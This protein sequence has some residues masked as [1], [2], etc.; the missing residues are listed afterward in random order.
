MAR[1][2][3][4]ALLLF[5]LLGALGAAPDGGFDLSDALPDNENKKPTAIPKKPSAGDDFDLGDAVVDGENDDPRPPNPPKPMPNPNPNHPSSSGSFSDADLADGVSGGEGKGGSDGGGSHRK[6]GEEADAPGVIP[7]IVGA[8]VVAV[9]GAISSFIAYQ[10]KK[11]CF[12]ENAEQG[13]VDMES[14]RNANAEPAVQRTL[15]EK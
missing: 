8:V 10:K 7:G 1:G 14:H 13:E 9:A 5:G 12:K 11:L 6:E 15:L 4:L 3:A 2:A